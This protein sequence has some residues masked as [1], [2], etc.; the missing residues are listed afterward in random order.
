[1]QSLSFK[2]KFLIFVGLLIFA[3]LGRLLPHLWNMTP[4]FAV[5]FF[6]T[7]FLGFRY[8]FFAGFIIMT[9]SDYFIGFYEIKVMLSVYAAFIISSLVAFLTKQSRSYHKILLLSV[10]GSLIFYFIT[11]SAVWLFTPYYSPDISGLAQS[12]LAGLPFLKNSILGNAFYSILLF[13]LYD[14]YL[15]LS[16]KN[17]FLVRQGARL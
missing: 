7:Y 3:V 17:Y 1:M 2:Y 11:N 12:L 5:L 16:S 15:Y 14:F 9:V 10:L 6:L 8:S 13:A 4:V